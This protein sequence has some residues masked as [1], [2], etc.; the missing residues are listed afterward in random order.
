M[1]LMLDLLFRWCMSYPLSKTAPDEDDAFILQRSNLRVSLLNAFTD[2]RTK[3]L[4][5][6]THDA[7][8]CDACNKNFVNKVGKIIGK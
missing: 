3:R 1:T 6:T 5:Q 4:L 2:I 8:G 7:P